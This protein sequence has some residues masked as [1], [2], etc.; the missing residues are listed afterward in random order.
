M[1][2]ITLSATFSVPGEKLYRAWLDPVHHAA[3]S[4]GGDAVIDARV[5]GTH[6]TGDGYI[7]GTFVE[8]VPGSK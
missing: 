7:T 1:E 6:S 4:Y 5:G 3:M 2:K 8:L